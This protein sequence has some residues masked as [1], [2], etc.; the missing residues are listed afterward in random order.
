MR[1]EILQKL[2][3]FREKALSYGVPSDEVERWLAAARPC[4]TLSP[5][6]D[7]PVVGRLGGPV[8]LPVGSPGL[9]PHTHLIASLDLAALPGDAM[10]LR[11]PSD[12]R[13]L[14]I[15]GYVD[16]MPADAFGKAVHVPASTPVEEY[17]VISG[18]APDDA[19]AH[20]EEDL[21]KE[22]ELRLTYDV[23]LPE[24]ESLI[25]AAA[26]PHARQLGDAWDDVRR[27]DRQLLTPRLQIDG[28]S[29]DPYRETDL[30]TA[31]AW[32]AAQKTGEEPRVEDWALLVQWNGVPRAGGQVYWT[33][34]KQNAAAG[35]F[36]ETS[37]LGFFEGPG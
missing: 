1:P 12:G 4:A 20:L 13:L 18:H 23:S 33:I 27:E 26:H 5:R 37:V 34:T 36:E 25:D 3:R 19:W 32:L 24:N 31:S 17:P 16:D 7:G 21:K 2:D 35:W 6:G 22:G 9:P 8:L 15:A 28:Y 11:L 30:V 10:T 14:L 29:S